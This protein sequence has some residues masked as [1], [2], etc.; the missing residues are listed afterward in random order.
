MLTRYKY[1]FF[2]LF[3]L[4]LYVALL[5]RRSLDSPSSRN[6]IAENW[7][8]RDNQQI[9]NFSFNPREE[10]DDANAGQKIAANFCQRHTSQLQFNCDFREN[11]TAVDFR[12]R[13]LR[14]FFTEIKIKKK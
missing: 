4:K 11:K 1:T 12:R 8:L 7:L 9:F 3:L 13:S 5:Q 14:D 6:S 10:R 2:D